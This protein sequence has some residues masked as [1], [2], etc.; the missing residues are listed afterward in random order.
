LLAV[1]RGQTLM[2]ASA[3]SQAVLD[4]YDLHGR[5]ELPW[6]RNPTPYRVWVSEIMLQ[7]TQVSTV[8]PYYE[9]FLARFPGLD[10][11]ADADLDEVL[12]LWTGLGY[13]ARAR[14]LY[15]TAR[16]L[17]EQHAGRFPTDIERLQALPGIGRSTAGAIL[18][19]ACGQRQ[20]ILDGNVKRVLAR[21]FAIE[22]WPGRSAVAKQLWA[23]A[24][25]QTPH[26]RVAHYNQAMMDIG[27]TICTRAK[28]NC[29]AC[30]LAGDCVARANDR[31]LDFPGRKPRKKVPVRSVQ[32]LLLRDR[33][34]G[35][36]L[37]QRPPAGVWGG[38]W[39]P[40]EI[41]QN[42]DPEDWCLNNLAARARENRRLAVRRHTFSHFHLDI[43]P[44]ELLLD[45][46]GL[47]VLEGV[48]RLWYKPSDSNA[49][50]LPAPIVR[51]IEE[52]H[53]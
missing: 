48:G 8:I 24:E 41:D 23:L 45:D 9:R 28:P 13:Y 6:Q 30:P 52:I 3:F 14:N 46:P 37:E 10:A 44:V 31:Q 42:E 22:G 29:T 21:C 35:L 17:K 19:L 38:L 26:D 4:W 27:A 5:K 25:T 36:L 12:H 34:G 40:P 43:L 47:A 2:D 18:S 49:L 15:K 11:L 1:R 32:M 16:A 50:G 7:Q 20:P 39:T 51:L 53:D 33:R